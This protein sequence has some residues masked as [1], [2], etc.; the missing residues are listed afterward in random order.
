VGKT[1]P[2]HRATSYVFNA[3]DR[4][5]GVDSPGS[6]PV[7]YGYNADGQRVVTDSHRYLRM[8]RAR[9]MLAEVSGGRINTRYIVLPSG[10]LLARVGPV[11]SQPVFYHFDALGST[12]A[13][14]DAS[15]RVLTRLSYDP[16][17]A[18]RS[19]PASDELFGFVGG[20]GVA[21]EKGDL[22]GMGLRFYA[23]ALG[24]FVSIDPLAIDADGSGK[25][26]STIALRGLDEG[27]TPY[28]TTYGYARG[29]PVILIDPYGDN[30]L[31]GA[32]ISA[33]GYV[34]IAGGVM[35]AGAGTEAVAAAGTALAAGQL[36]PAAG[37][38]IAGGLTVY[39]GGFV[40]E[41]GARC[42]AIGLVEFSK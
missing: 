30:V 26:G 13:L 11:D 5:V 35:T 27:P 38:A 1:G 39:A 34:I 28:G 40:A 19:V 25:H 15:G 9:P 10:Q 6:A 20:N 41:M 14:T 2:G 18:R 36:A 12:V 24:R 42:L 7:R 21:D 8:G 4:L 37:L 22:L 29:N 17:G 31:T 3:L 23:P 16:Y 32:L 33:A